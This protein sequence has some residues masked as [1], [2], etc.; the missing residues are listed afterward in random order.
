ML[1]VLLQTNQ[2]VFVRLLQGAFRVSH[3]Q[4]LSGPQ[5]YHVENCIKTLSESGNLPLHILFLAHWCG[6]KTLLVY[7]NSTLCLGFL[8]WQCVFVGYSIRFKF[9]IYTVFDAGLPRS[10]IWWTFG[11]H[12]QNFIIE[13]VPTQK[14]KWLHMSSFLTATWVHLSGAAQ[15]Y[16]CLS[17]EHYTGSWL[18]L[19]ERDKG[20]T[21]E[22]DEEMSAKDKHKTSYKD[23]ES[24]EEDKGTLEEDTSHHILL[25][26]QHSL[27]EAALHQYLEAAIQVSIITC[28]I[29]PSSISPFWSTDSYLILHQAFSIRTCHFSAFCCS[30]SDF[31]PSWKEETSNCFP[32]ASAHTQRLE[33]VCVPF[34]CNSKSLHLSYKS[35]DFP[36]IS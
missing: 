8:W 9:K 25:L 26:L 3:C 21:S 30:N 14:S 29:I 15:E 27:S 32:I 2:P 1:Y 18:S 10:Q 17:S 6:I 19:S 13:T 16:Q 31:P 35:R 7:K 28:C 22:T 23:K 20:K 33:R 5:R 24:E 36:Y 4:W 11:P 34:A 12:L